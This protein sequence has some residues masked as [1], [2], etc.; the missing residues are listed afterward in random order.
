[1]PTWRTTSMRGVCDARYQG[2]SHRKA[3]SRLGHLNP[4]FILSNPI[5]RAR[6]RV[7][8]ACQSWRC[9]RTAWRRSARTSRR[10]LAN[11]HSTGSNMRQQMPLPA[12]IAR[13]A[14]IKRPLRRCSLTCSSRLTANRRARSFLISMP[15]T[16]PFTASRKAAFSTAI[17]AVSLDDA[18]QLVPP[19]PRCGVDLRRSQPPLHLGGGV[20]ED[21]KGPLPIRRPAHLLAASFP[22][23]TQGLCDWYAR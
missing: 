23:R 16:T 14:T 13:S 20:R 8:R 21:G 11:R 10:W 9:Y 15:R 19:P 3:M 4:H 5:H 18:R 12:A 6:R 7:H 1:M 17:T 2:R 22:R